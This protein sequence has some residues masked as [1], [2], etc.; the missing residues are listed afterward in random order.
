MKTYLF[1]YGIGRSFK[2]TDTIIELFK[3]LCGQIEIKY[4]LLKQELIINPRSGELGKI[5]YTKFDKKFKKIIHEFKLDEINKE[6]IINRLKSVEDSYNDGYSSNKNLINQ[7]QILNEISLQIKPISE[8]KGQSKI[9]LIRDDIKLDRFS[10]LLIKVYFKFIKIKP[11]HVYLS[12]Y[13]WHNGYN[14]KFF[15]ADP[16]TSYIVTSRYQKIYEFIN[17][18]NYLHAEELLSYIIKNN[19]LK[20]YPL[21]LRFGRVRI[22]GKIKW[23][24]WFPSITRVRDFKKV[25]FHL[26]KDE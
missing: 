8:E 12:C 18:H 20:V 26:F 19:K 23:D 9:I 11:N 24:N 7:L 16:K 1:I 4:F 10:E 22:S 25:I 5:N 13:S 3:N 2:S 14:D 6:N 15:I 17:T 21:F